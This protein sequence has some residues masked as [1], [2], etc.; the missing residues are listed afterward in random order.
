MLRVQCLGGHKTTRGDDDDGL[1]CH[2]QSPRIK[3]AYICPDSFFEKNLHAYA[4]R[5]MY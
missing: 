3:S 2:S 4:F 5:Q 1:T